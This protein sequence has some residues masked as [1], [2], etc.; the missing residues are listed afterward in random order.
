MKRYSTLFCLLA[1]MAA[2]SSFAFAQDLKEVRKTVALSAGGEVKI[3]TF[4]GSVTVT[5]GDGG[6]RRGLGR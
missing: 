2:G 4:K 1:L 5:A 6:A 3:D